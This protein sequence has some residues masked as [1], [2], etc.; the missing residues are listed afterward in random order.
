MN[1]PG[2]ARAAA[3]EYDGRVNTPSRIHASLLLIAALAGCDPAPITDAGPGV[4]T[5][6]PRPDAAPVPG[7]PSGDCGSVRL[8]SFA[9]NPSGGWCELP[10]N[11]PIL[12]S[13]V[14]EGL[15]GAIA[16]PWN[17]SSYEGAPGESCGEC[18]EIDTVFETRTVMIAD[19][20]P[21]EGN[22]LCAGE[23]FHI[24]LAN[25]AAAAL[26]GGALDEGSARRVACPVTGNAFVYVSDVNVTYMRLQFANHRIPVRTA[27]W[28]ATGAGVTGSNEWT[29]LRRSGGAWE[30]IGE[31]RPTNRG[32]DGVVFRITSAQ[33][34]VLTSEAVVPTQGPIATAFD[35]GVQFDDMMPSSG[36]SCSYTTPADVFVNGFGGIDQVRWSINPWGEAEMG[37]YGPFETDCFE[38]SCLRVERFAQWTGFHLYYRQAFPTSS[39]SRLRFR[40]RTRGDS[41]NIAVGL[42]NDGTRCME[43][44]VEITEAWT[45]YTLDVTASCAGSPVINGVTFDNGGMLVDLLLDDVRFER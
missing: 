30:M 6:A 22:P 36:G 4:D 34:Q 31:G 15:I 38:G 10:T 2:Q 14:R 28:R 42:S 12:P 27:E 7:P 43:S 16:E 33:G 19:L 5:N 26:R 44:R 9:A 21:I 17:G 23:H 41:T 8:T 3:S 11:L 18:W 20:C 35:L 39:F 13:F 25:Q 37:F 32:G 29:P 40:A 1:E 45:E 24:D